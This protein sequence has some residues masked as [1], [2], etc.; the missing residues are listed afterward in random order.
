MQTTTIALLIAT[1]A[2]ILALVGLIGIFVS[3][4][5]K[6]KTLEDHTAAIKNHSDLLRQCQERGLVSADQ[7]QDAQALCV[8][9]QSTD[10]QQILAEISALKADIKNNREELKRE[11]AETNKEFRSI[12]M[13][14]ADRLGNIDG[15]IGR[16]RIVER[17]EKLLT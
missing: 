17:E 3:L 14:M 9:Q 4:G 13:R 16:H 8:K 6:D 5:R 11:S 1:P 7:C 10:N 12:L 15:V 2:S